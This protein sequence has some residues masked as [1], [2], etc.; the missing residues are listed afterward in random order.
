MAYYPTDIFYEFRTQ[1]VLFKRNNV[2]TEPGEYM[3]LRSTGLEGGRVIDLFRVEAGINGKFEAVGTLG[4][5]GLDRLVKDKAVIGWTDPIKFELENP[6][7]KRS[8]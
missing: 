3:V 4:R 5:S 6:K 7:K 1:R 8:K 2:P